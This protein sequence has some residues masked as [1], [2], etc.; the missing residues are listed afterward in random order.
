[1]KFNWISWM[2]NRSI[3][4]N[5]KLYFGKEDFDFRITTRDKTFSC[6]KVVLR[7]NCGYF[8]KLTD[9]VKMQEIYMGRDS[10][11]LQDVLFYV[12]YGR[13]PNLAIQSCK[14]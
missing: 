3:N 1:M 12:Y 13:I 9:D 6:H 4:P 2:N 14:L 7:H 8:E 10:E 5:S 11:I